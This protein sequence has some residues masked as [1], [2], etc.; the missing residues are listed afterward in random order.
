MKLLIRIAVVAVAMSAA[1]LFASA[2]ANAGIG[3]SI[4]V[5]GIGIH[6]GGPVNH[7]GVPGYYYGPGYYPPGPCDA[8][9]YYYTGDCGYALYDGRIFVNGVWVDGPHYYRWYDGAPLFWYRGG[10]YGWPDWTGVNFGWNH[11]EG[12]GWHGGHWDR[13]W[14]AAH[15]GWHG[16]VHVHD[17][18]THDHDHG[19]DRRDH[20]TSTHG[21]DH[22]HDH[23]DHD[24]VTSAH[25]TE[26]GHGDDRGGDRH[27]H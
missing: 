9:D 3:I 16:L 25:G 12:W 26:H 21:T 17:V 14:G 7:V 2:P 11:F 15:G 23:H 24:H 6:I 27:H 22:G 13:G 1:A 10:W 4:G 18:R 5:P 8:Y 20:V 19:H